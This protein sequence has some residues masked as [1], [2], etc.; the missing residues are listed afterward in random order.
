[1]FIQEGVE[2][3]VSLI[4]NQTYTLSFYQSVNPIKTDDINGIYVRQFDPGI[5]KIYLNGILETTS[6]IATYTGNT[7][8]TGT[9]PDNSWSKVEIEFTT[10]STPGAT[11][12]SFFT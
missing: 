12:L 1:M 2:T 6:P 11:L 8:S 7:T 3:T 5:W 9:F 10:G 4:P